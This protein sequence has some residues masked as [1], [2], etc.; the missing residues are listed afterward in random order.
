MGTGVVHQH[1]D[2]FHGVGEPSHTGQVGQIEMADLDVGRHLGGGQLGL[3]DSPAGNHHAVT[4]GGQHPSGRFADAA[5][6]ASDDDAHRGP[7]SRA[8]TDLSVKRVS[9]RSPRNGLILVDSANRTF[10][11]SLLALSRPNVSF[12]ERCL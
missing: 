12:G 6:A 9:S 3:R 4:R 7:V 5:V 10:C 2:R 8:W 11:T 1:I